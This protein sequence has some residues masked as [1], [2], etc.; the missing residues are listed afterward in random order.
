MLALA[1]SGLQ[2]SIEVDWSM[3]D[4]EDVVY[5]SDGST[6]LPVNSVWQLIW[7]PDQ[8][9]SGFNPLNP[10]EV[11][12]TEEVLVE[13]RNPDAGYIFN[14]NYQTAS[15]TYIGGYVYTRVFDYQGN[16]STFNLIDLDGMWYD[17]STPIDGPLADM[18]NPISLKTNHYPFT[19]ENT[20]SQQYAIPEPSTLM[21]TV[22]ALGA[23]YGLRR[24]VR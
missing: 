18:G 6:L 13:Y 20:L 14:Q 4:L 11:D 8:A 24:R 3:P 5:Q 9:I 21:L 10:F 12:S 1:F 15:D 19:G 23:L 2:A 22:V 17:E 7:T 16:T